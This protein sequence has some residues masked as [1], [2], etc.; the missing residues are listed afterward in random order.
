MSDGIESFSDVVDMGMGRFGNG[1]TV[2]AAQLKTLGVSNKQAI[3]LTRFNTQVLG[4][5]NDT[6]LMLT[7]SMVDTAMSFGESANSIVDAN[8]LTSSGCT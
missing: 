2:L 6:S 7:K 8:Q 4:V 1:L 3:E 5:N